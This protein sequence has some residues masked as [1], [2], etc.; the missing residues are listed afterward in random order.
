MDTSIAIAL[1]AA[2]LFV[3]IVPA[4]LRRGGE[5]PDDEQRTTDRART[6]EVPRVP[7][8][9]V[10]PSR[11][12]LLA[13]RAHP[14]AVGLPD[15]SAEYVRTAPEISLGCEQPRFTVVDGTAAEV[16]DAADAPGEAAQVPHASAGAGRQHSAEAACEEL[17]EAEV[18][19]L[20][21][22]AGSAVLLAGAQ[23][24]AGPEASPSARP[25]LTVVTSPR[26]Q[27]MEPAM[28]HS[29]RTAP[30]RIAAAAERMPRALPADVRARLDHSYSAGARRAARGPGAGAREEAAVREG[31]EADP[32]ATPRAGA[33]GS[34]RTASGAPMAGA[35]AAG[36]R[37]AD[38]SRAGAG[39]QERT[40]AHRVEVSAADRRRIRGLRRILPF[41]GLGFLVLGAA[42]LVMLG[43]VLFGALPW[44]VPVI[45]AALALACLF[46]LRSLNREITAL[47]R[48]IE[49]AENAPAARVRGAAG[50]ARE[51]VQRAGRQAAPGAAGPRAREVV[52]LGASADPVT[53]EVPVVRAAAEEPAAAASAPGAGSAA[54]APAAVQAATAAKAADDAAEPA[55]VE[56]E[57]RSAG[58]HERGAP[59]EK[60]APAERTERARTSATAAARSIVE[61]SH[62]APSLSLG[63]APATGSGDASPATEAPAAETSTAEAPAPAET[64]PATARA[65][66][67]SSAPAAE[68]AE[69]PTAEPGEGQ[70]ASE[71]SEEPPAEASTRGAAGDALARR[72]RS[73]DWTPSA[74]PTP[75][76]VDAPVAERQVPRPVVAD[77]S[78]YSLAPASRESLAE[79]FADELGYRPALADAAAEGEADDSPLGHGRTATRR[80]TAGDASSAADEPAQADLG[81]ILARRRA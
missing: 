75:T 17:P 6:V 69:A 61:R 43:F 8:C 45:P 31:R 63:F 74:V 29:P 11:P 62:A 77:A 71:R 39:A 73:G 60:G 80:R 72:M 32:R 68:S 1:I 76:Y 27:P 79:Q 13:D 5:V 67:A 47:R 40:G 41:C 2:A 50:R 4:A 22:A 52:E 21:L 54:K 64:A 7:A 49:A 37:A 46:V 20:P 58:E 78:S 12:V 30:R 14:A 81:G 16:R 65:A 3:F 18:F 33:A 59:E 25:S 36:S 28:N 51:A 15:A 19:E 48:G 38:G 42:A 26:S 9:A 66:D 53:A 44:G 35:P 10:D 57:P 55:P 56:T 24:S 34:P 23:G 70:A